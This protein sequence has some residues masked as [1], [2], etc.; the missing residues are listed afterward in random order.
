[1]Y[2]NDNVEIKNNRTT[3]KI[4]IVLL[5]ICIIIVFLDR[6]LGKF[7]SMIDLIHQ[8]GLLPGAIKVGFLWQIQAKNKSPARKNVQIIIG[9]F[10]VSTKVY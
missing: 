8:C 9:C 3:W 1:M 5:L 4:Q 7:V 2:F 6:H 10:I